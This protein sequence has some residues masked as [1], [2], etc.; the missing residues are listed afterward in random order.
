MIT[1][2]FWA[3]VVP[4]WSTYWIPATLRGIRVAK[5]TQR[6]PRDPIIGCVLVKLTVKLPVAAFVPPEFEGSLAIEPGHYERVPAVV[7][8]E[9]LEP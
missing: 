4:S 6:K 3:Q 8:A 2:T 1:A 5:I 7:S 9:R